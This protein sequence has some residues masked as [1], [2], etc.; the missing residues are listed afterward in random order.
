MKIKK[1]TQ[2]YANKPGGYAVR[3]KV[4]ARDVPLSELQKLPGFIR[5]TTEDIVFDTLTNAKSF[6]NSKI[7]VDARKAA[8]GNKDFDKTRIKFRKPKLFNRIIELAEEGKTSVQKIGEDPEVVKLNN[9]KTIKYG[10]IKKIITDE[11]GKK[12]F[13]KVAETKQPFKGA[14]RIALEANISNVM[15]DYFRS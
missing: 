3:N 2:R 6:N 5:K 14:D 15:N 9:G 4:V 10:S 12:F 8:L 11:K 1:L 13:D 7:A